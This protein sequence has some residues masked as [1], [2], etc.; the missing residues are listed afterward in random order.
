MLIFGK[1]AL[2]IMDAVLSEYPDKSQNFYDASFW[3]LAK[4]T[5]SFVTKPEQSLFFFRGKQDGRRFLQGSFF[6]VVWV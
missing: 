5:T 1:S 6:R 2:W 3:T 4:R